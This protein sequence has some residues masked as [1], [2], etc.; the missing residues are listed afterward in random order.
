MELK[1]LTKIK[2]MDWYNVA[3]PVRD[4]SAGLLGGVI[5]LM[6]RLNIVSGNF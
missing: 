6:E 5:G 4:C 2:P 1:S 3:A